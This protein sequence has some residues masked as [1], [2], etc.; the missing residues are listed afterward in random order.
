MQLRVSQYIPQESLLSLPVKT[1]L[2]GMCVLILQSFENIVANCIFAGHGIWQ[3]FGRH[4][5]SGCPK[6]DQV[7][8]YDTISKGSI[9]ADR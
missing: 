2:S 9:F 3:T 1:E 8:Y 5:D 7:P 4:S 6:V